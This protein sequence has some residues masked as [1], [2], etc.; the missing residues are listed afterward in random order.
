MNSIELEKLSNFINVLNIICLNWF[1]IHLP[2]TL[3]IRIN[4]MDLKPRR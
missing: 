3:I 1:I 4:N 2:R